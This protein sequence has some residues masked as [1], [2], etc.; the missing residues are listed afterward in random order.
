MGYLQ[1]FCANLLV[2]KI[3]SLI[4]IQEFYRNQT[5]LGQIITDL[6]IIVCQLQ[7]LTFSTEANVTI[8]CHNW[9]NGVIFMKSEWKGMHWISKHNRG[10]FW[11][12]FLFLKT[13]YNVGLTKSTETDV[14]CIS[15]STAIFS[16]SSKSQ[17]WTWTCLGCQS[18]GIHNSVAHKSFR[19]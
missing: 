5:I 6:L 11:K 16:Q 9:A 13:E 4:K 14:G 7:T 8:L 2:Q 12:K 17:H 19:R 10:I 18:C 15:S 3:K 1:Y